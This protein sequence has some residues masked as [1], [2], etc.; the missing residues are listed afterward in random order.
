MNI[1]IQFVCFLNIAM[2]CISP[3]PKKAKK[4]EK[5]EFINIFERMHWTHNMNS[6]FISLN[7]PLMNQ[8]STFHFMFFFLS[9]SIVQQQ[10]HCIF[11][12]MA[13]SKRK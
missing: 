7:S 9:L 3:H 10:Q 6:F 4:K 8:K 2:I 5:R 1:E 12:H 13:G 11:M